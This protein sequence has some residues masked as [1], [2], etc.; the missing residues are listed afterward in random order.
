M[1]VDGAQV[2][3]QLRAPLPLP[4]HPALR[5]PSCCCRRRPR[6]FK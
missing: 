3:R 4:L 5:R 2:H 6:V 1:F